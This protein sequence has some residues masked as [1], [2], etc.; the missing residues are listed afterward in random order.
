MDR[1]VWQAMVHRV[2]ESDTTEATKHS[3]TQDYKVCGWLNIQMWWDH[4]YRRQ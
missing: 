1:G 2:A 3:T 4:G